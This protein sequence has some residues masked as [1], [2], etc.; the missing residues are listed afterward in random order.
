ME[1]IQA[2][3]DV[4]VKNEPSRPGGGGRVR[5]GQGVRG[6]RSEGLGGGGQG[7]RGGG[8]GPGE[9]GLGR[10]WRG[11]GGAGDGGAGR[12]PGPGGGGGGLGRAMQV[13]P[14]K[15]TLQLASA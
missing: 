3:V 10:G 9:Q 4:D 1:N 11:G 14:L 13:E 6:T 8:Q 2:W 5:G 15:P 12:G 7:P